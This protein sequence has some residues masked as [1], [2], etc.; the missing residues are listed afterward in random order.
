M[1]LDLPLYHLIANYHTDQ[2]WHG[3]HCYWKANGGQ[4]SDVLS[5]PITKGVRR[6]ATAA[7]EASSSLSGTTPLPWLPEPIRLNIEPLKFQLLSRSSISELFSNRARHIYSSDYLAGATVFPMR[8]HEPTPTGRQPERRECSL[9]S[10]QTPWRDATQVS[11][12]LPHIPH[13]R[14]ILP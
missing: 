2:L 3:F 12:D 13:R 10:W 1:N 4:L 14:T 6:L 7:T 9:P 11:R 8:K 5:R